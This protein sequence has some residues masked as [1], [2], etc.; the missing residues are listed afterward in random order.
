MGKFQYFLLTY[1]SIYNSCYEI[2]ANSEA[3]KYVF[4]E[5]Q[6]EY[7]EEGIEEILY[8]IFDYNCSIGVSPDNMLVHAFYRDCCQRAKENMD[9]ILNDYSIQN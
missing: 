1:P 6:N 5:E 7:T 3:A 2:V 8:D 9:I 4:L